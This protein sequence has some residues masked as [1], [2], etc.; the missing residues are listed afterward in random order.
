MTT[1]RPVSSSLSAERRLQTSALL[2]NHHLRQHQLR[3]PPALNRPTHS[4]PGINI[5][6]FLRH[7][8]TGRYASLIVASEETANLTR[9]INR[10]LSL[11]DNRHALR[12][13]R[14]HRMIILQRAL[15]MTNTR[16]IRSSLRRATPVTRSIPPLLLLSRHQGSI[17][18][19][20]LMTRPQQSSSHRTRNSSNRR[21]NRT[22]P[23]RS[24]RNKFTHLSNRL[25]QTSNT[26]HR[27]TRARNRRNKRTNPSRGQ[28]NRSLTSHVA[29]RL[30]RIIFS[31]EPSYS[32][33]QYQQQAHP[34]SLH[35]TAHH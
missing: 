30:R 13:T 5:Q 7:N 35:Y 10:L 28:S 12:G 31:F 1:L 26:S 16:P 22:R 20:R 23:N 19:Q 29:R 2:I 17:L 4:T 33:F 14:R 15:K 25:N 8:F 32:Q 34:T 18:R 21:R 11:I 3:Q 24:L 27:D 9:T 6:Q